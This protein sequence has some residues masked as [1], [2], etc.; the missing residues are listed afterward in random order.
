MYTLNITNG[1][2]AVDAVDRNN[3]R[4]LLLFFCDLSQP[5]SFSWSVT[6]FSLLQ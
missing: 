1:Q 3:A 6:F 5:Y 2:Q 4:L